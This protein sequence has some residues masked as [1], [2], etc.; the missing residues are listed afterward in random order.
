MGRARGSP[1]CAGTP[2]SQKQPRN[3]GPWP[4]SPTRCRGWS[5]AGAKAPARSAARTST[6]TR[7][8]EATLDLV[9]WHHQDL[10][11]P[12]D[13]AFAGTRVLDVAF[14]DVATNIAPRVERASHDWSSAPGR[15]RVCLR[16]QNVVQR[17]VRQDGTLKYDAQVGG[18]CARHSR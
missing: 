14:A 10:H 2:A 13:L 6:L 5:R 15:V 9:Q 18:N 4:A 8:G 7:S 11:G 16:R 17:G 1:V 3:R 12:A